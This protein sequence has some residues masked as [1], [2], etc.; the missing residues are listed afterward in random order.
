MRY[1]ARSLQ[2]HF[3][4]KTYQ[5]NYPS[6]HQDLAA[7]AREL[8]AF[9][10]SL[11]AEVVH[12]VG[13][14]LG[15]LVIRALF[16]YYPNQAPGRLV[17]LGSPARG[18]YVAAVLQRSWLGRRIV[19]PALAQYLQEGV[20]WQPLPRELGTI[21][22][23][24]ALGFGRLFPGLP[25]PN[26]GTVAVSETQ[27]VDASDHIVLPVSHTSML[28]SPQVARQVGIFLTQGQFDRLESDR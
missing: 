5:F 17:M 7:D 11:E 8:N 26:D 2:K 3:F 16:H 13:H 14:S 4:L 20:L 15:G 28:F 6:T 9:L 25:R 22:G 27:T 19:G 23:S 12:L 10:G 21:A 1:L 18:S 24:I